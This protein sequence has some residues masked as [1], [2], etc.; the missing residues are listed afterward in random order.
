[1]TDTLTRITDERRAELEAPPRVSIQ[2]DGVIQRPSL[3]QFSLW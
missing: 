3:L 1:M 2:V